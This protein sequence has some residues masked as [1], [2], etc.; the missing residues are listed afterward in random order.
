[1]PIC[2]AG[3]G[4]GKERTERLDSALRRIELGRRHE[5]GS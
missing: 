2:L 3:I 5:L 1:M 4:G